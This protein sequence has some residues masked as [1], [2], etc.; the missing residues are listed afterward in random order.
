MELLVSLTRYTSI[1]PLLLSLDVDPSDT[2]YFH[3]CDRLALL[4][5]CPSGG[6]L[7][8]ELHE[9]S[10]SQ[11]SPTAVLLVAG[12]SSSGGADAS[13]ASWRR[14][15]SGSHDSALMKVG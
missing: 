15:K 13:S 10:N 1:V 5:T 3:R 2:L 9:L 8:L 7:V 12:Y 6:E 4:S 14:R 11:T